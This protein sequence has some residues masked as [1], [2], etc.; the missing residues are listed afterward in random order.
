M[1]KLGPTTDH[2]LL[3][4]IASTTNRTIVR[5]RGKQEIFGTA[6]LIRLVV[7][8]DR[9]RF[10]VRT[11][12]GHPAMIVEFALVRLVDDAEKGLGQYQLP[13]PQ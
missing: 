8:L 10:V 13:K 6:K 2:H 11:E 1:T 12:P 3:T 4:P 7:A 5:G 9:F